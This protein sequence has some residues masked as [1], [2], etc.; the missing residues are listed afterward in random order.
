MRKT[1]ESTLLYFSR[2]VTIAL[3]QLM[4]G[5]IGPRANRANHVLLPIDLTIIITS[6]AADD[7]SPFPNLYQIS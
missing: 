3:W 7:Q 6:A 5:R 4:T 2:A 1:V